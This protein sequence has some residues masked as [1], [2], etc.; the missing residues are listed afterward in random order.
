MSFQLGGALPVRGYHLNG[1]CIIS[2]PWPGLLVW[3]KGRHTNSPFKNEGSR[4]TGL[5]YFV[6]LEFCVQYYNTMDR[7]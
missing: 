3:M 4:L 2:L 5:L 1:N 6:R 7:V